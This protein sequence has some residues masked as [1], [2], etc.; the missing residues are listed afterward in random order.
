MKLLAIECSTAQGSVA[1]VEG[2]CIVEEVVFESPRGRG[3]ALFTALEDILKGW[4]PDGVVVGTGPGSY[5]GIR[6]AIAAGW[7]VA[8]SRGIPARG[9]LSVL[10]FSEENFTLLGD[11]RAGQWFVAKVSGG[12]SNGEPELIPQG[13]VPEHERLITT[14]ELGISGAAVLRPRASLLA[15]HWET[16]G[17]LEPVYLKPPHITA[18]RPTAGAAARSASP[19]QET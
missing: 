18:P 14:T 4:E 6:I 7:G 1:R 2:E 9:V 16:A 5:N 13:Q 17:K 10:G 8:R 11:A 3:A 15:R 19:V 12:V